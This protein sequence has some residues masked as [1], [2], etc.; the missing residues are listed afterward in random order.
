MPINRA[1][2]NTIP[3]YVHSTIIKEISFGKIIRVSMFTNHMWSKGRR[4]LEVLQ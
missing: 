3:Y 4:I 1:K 2:N